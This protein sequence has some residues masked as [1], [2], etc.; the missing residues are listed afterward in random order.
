MKKIR[1]VIIL[2]VISMVCGPI[3]QIYSNAQSI[4]KNQMF[5]DIKKKQENNNEFDNGS[6]IGK[7]TLSEENISN[8]TL[9]GKVWGFLKY[10][11]PKVAE[12]KYNWDYELFRI[13]PKV[14]DVDKATRD[15]NLYSWIESQGEF[16]IKDKI[17]PVLGEVKIAA[18]LDWI[19]NSNLS[20]ELVLQLTNIKNAERTGINNYVS[21]HWNVGNPNFKNEKPYEAMK[22]PDVGYQMLSL[23]RY[24][25]I[26]EYYFPYKNLIEENW[27]GVLEEFIP[28]F[29]NASNELE[30]KLA[31]LELIGR[32][33]DTHADIYGNPTLYDYFGVSLSPVKISF[34]EN[35][36]VVTGYY[37]EDLGKK[38]GL[39]LGDIIVGINKKPI[40]N[41]V[42]D[43]LKYY[44]ASNYPTKL[45]NISSDL[46]RSND[47]FLDIEFIRENKKISSKIQ[48]YPIDKIYA[49][50]SS[51]KKDCFKLI[52]SDIGYIY[53]G[54]I[55]NK[56]ISEIM[57]KTKN[58]KG[59][60]IDLR[61][62]PSEFIVFT[63]GSYLVPEKSEFAKI[64]TGSTFDPGVFRMKTPIK[65]GKKNLDYY[66]G[67][68]VIIVN[69]ETQSQAEY[70]AMA[71]KTAPNVTVIGSTTA[72]AD[73][74]VSEFYL[75]GKIYTMISGIGIYYPNG[76]ETQR[77]G[78]VPDIEV[79]PTIEGIKEGRDELLEKAIEI[80]KGQ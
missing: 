36:A 65:V 43:R 25:N 10:Y 33:H 45:R 18:N 70:T 54:T 29:I 3:N 79:H 15:K 39:Q 28:K 26:I 24:W 64:T 8:L 78:I 75:P 40:N 31:A 34:I 11:H 55:K 50:N 76:G 73:G 13:L 80:I 59:L 37:N 17:K 23:Y 21:L 44:P 68:V 30:Y 5:H 72:G 62:Y 14:I 35:K 46:L 19:T 16:K 66:K 51:T 6:K 27:D 49:N 53:P 61:C 48:C 63:L 67:K 41:V 2:C 52:N 57:T 58:T 9:L 56:Y 71:F 74:N 60:I 1:L 38:S 22:Y 12:G 69:E 42:E 4:N 47:D 20:K 32:V 7:I 77:I